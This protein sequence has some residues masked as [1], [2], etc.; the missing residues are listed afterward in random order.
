MGSQSMA[1]RLVWEYMQRGEF[2]LYHFR[3][4]RE[5]VS[6][7]PWKSTFEGFEVHQ[8]WSLFKYHFLRAQEQNVRSQTGR[9]ES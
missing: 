2:S 9:K 6:K 4:L 3:L 8:C 7:V 1:Q 5:L